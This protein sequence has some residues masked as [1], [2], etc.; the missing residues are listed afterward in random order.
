MKSLMRRFWTAAGIAFLSRRKAACAVAIL[1]MGLA[2]GANTAVF[3]VVRAFLLSS[4]AVPDAGRVMLLAPVRELPGRGEVIFAEAYP[5]YLM[6]RETQRT[7]A[8]LACVLQ[9][10]ASWDDG[11]EPRAMP[12][13]RVTASFFSTMQVPLALGRGFRSSEEGPN[14][15]S[16]VILSHAL[17]E[18][19]FARDPRVLDRTIRINGL[20]HTVVG[21]MP[22]G[23]A[24]PA[25]TQL[26]LPFDIPAAARTSV[27][28]ARQLSVFGRLAAGVTVRDAQ[29][30]M[31]R[32]TSRAVEAF[33]ADNR[34]YRYSIRSLRDSL[35][36]KAD[37]T[38]LLV[39]AGA[40]VLLLLAVLNLASLLIAWGMDR[41]QE[42]GV[43]VVL[44][45][46]AG[47]VAWLL[48]A[49]SLLI[50]GAGTVVGWGLGWL[51]LPAVRLLDSTPAL[52]YFLGGVRMDWGVLGVSTAV[53]T[54]AAL[55]AAA[56]PA[57]FGRRTDPA[58]SLDGAG[59]GSSPS[60]AAVRWQQGLVVA[61]AALSVVVL[62]AGGLVGASL[63]NLLRVPDGFV[64]E[65]R[66]VLRTQLPDAE[67]DTHE[68][69]EAFART[70]LEHTSREPAIAGFGF[71]NTLPVVDPPWGGRFFIDT[72]EGE[73]MLFHL[74][75]VSP[76][77]LRTMEI[78]LVEG[79]LLDERDLS[80]S[81]P[82]AV[83][84]EA[85][86]RRYWPSGDAVGRR[87][88]RA[89][90][91]NAP[92]LEVVGIVG[93]TMDGG[94]H[95]PAGEAVYVP[96]HQWS[97]NRLSL[98]VTPSGPAD[99]AV[100]AVRRALRAADPR[101]APSEAARLESLVVRANALPRLQ[102]VLLGVFAVVALGIVGLGTYGLMSQQ[103]ASREREF[104][105]R[106]ALGSA[107]SAVGRVVLGQVTRLIV[108]G[109]AGGVVAVWLLEQVMRAFVFGIEP[110]STPLLVT[111]SLAVGVFGA[112]A[113]LPTAFRAMRAD[114][115][116]AISA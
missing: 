71:T 96:F 66:L 59:R 9:G 38:I 28:G 87:L 46:G 57:W 76:G 75:R 61:Q 106:L 12:V 29:A 14:P 91:P 70:V 100:A 33:P 113:T 79:R 72:R 4:L 64:S 27:T 17:W 115:R 55:L 110:R 1:T 69:R 83:V 53:A 95:A 93:N 89:A 41:R 43:R 48:V 111:V 23:F 19:A 40:L 44:G 98:V 24:Q 60:R 5:N 80:T 37:S 82:V 2:L 39:Q 10:T 114:I 50:V 112:V 77:Y 21:V 62:C 30:D 109:V 102:A 15:A 49:Q 81:V 7:F 107:P 16:V 63:R 90:P 18:S 97:V 36:G 74:R 6:L 85:L 54:V 42:M 8:D 25:P 105:L 51:F 11:S 52:A 78:P 103:V 99:A 20:A 104:A 84:S 26:W 3:S 68:K 47:R 31:E 56:V 88:L 32:L 13:S 34:D 35:L 67:Y 65:G 86:A 116:R 108:P 58:R 45:A 101:L 22:A 94:Y 73:A 92:P